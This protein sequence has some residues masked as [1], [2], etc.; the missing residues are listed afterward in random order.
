MFKMSKI[1]IF[2]LCTMLIKTITGQVIRN[3]LCVDAMAY[4]NPMANIAYGAE[5]ANPWYD[6]YGLNLA[7][8]A[9]NGCGFSVQSSSP[10]TPNGV[11]ILSENMVIEGPLAVNGQ[12][13][14]LGTI[15]VEGSLPASGAG[16]VSYGCGNG[17][18]GITNEAIPSYSLANQYNMASMA[19]A[20]AGMAPN[21]AGMAMKNAMYGMGGL[22]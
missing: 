5:Y 22:Y 7:T 2:C 17:N 19:P 3:P 18:V 12:M 10:I 1:V 6:N 13:P 14:F 11:S 4:A 16:V 20:L 15:G 8:L 21:M 9:A